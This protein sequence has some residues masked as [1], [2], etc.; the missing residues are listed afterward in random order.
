MSTLPV[1][2]DPCPFCSGKELV[3]GA[4]T[5]IAEGN[6]P[7]PDFVSVAC[8]GC[9]AIGPAMPDEYTARMAWNKLKVKG[10]KTC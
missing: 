1:S 4:R 5:D 8:P 9:K 2:P 6:W 3:V 10:R 7:N